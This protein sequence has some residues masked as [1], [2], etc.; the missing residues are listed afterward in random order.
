MNFYEEK[1]AR[2]IPLYWL[3]AFEASK[4]HTSWLK[5]AQHFNGL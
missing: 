2:Y 3:M 1:R 5:F 4:I